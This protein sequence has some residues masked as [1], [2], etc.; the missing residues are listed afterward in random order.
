M[1]QM[2]GDPESWLHL[3]EFVV[4]QAVRLL[5]SSQRGKKWAVP[6]GSIWLKTLW[7]TTWC[8]SKALCGRNWASQH[9]RSMTP[10]L[11][12]CQGA[13]STRGV[14][15]DGLQPNSIGLQPTGIHAC[16]MSELLFQNWIGHS[17]L[18]HPS[19]LIQQYIGRVV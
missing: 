6:F 14:M 9:R 15:V 3:G 16:H 5:L 4:S 13:R 17:S 19:G 10:S 11:P 2:L 1:K 7:I 12:R 18:Q 8:H